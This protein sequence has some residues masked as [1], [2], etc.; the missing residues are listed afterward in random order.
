MYSLESLP[1]VILKLY[2]TS[3]PMNQFIRHNQELYCSIGGMRVH[4]KRT[5]YG[6]VN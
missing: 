6:S 4:V 1:I 2:K 5:L 3:A